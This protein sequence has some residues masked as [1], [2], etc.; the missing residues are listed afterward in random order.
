MTRIIQFC[1]RTETYGKTETQEHRKISLET[2]DRLELSKNRTTTNNTETIARSEIIMKSWEYYDE[3]ISEKERVAQLISLAEDN[4]FE[5][6]KNRNGELITFAEDKLGR[7][8]MIECDRKGRYKTLTTFS[9]YEDRIWKIEK[10][11]HT[12]IVFFDFGKNYTE[13][14]KTAS[15]NILGQSTKEVYCYENGKPLSYSKYRQSLFKEDKLIASH[16]L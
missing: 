1:P 14:I 15:N 2:K 9:P 8:V 3:A 6:M 13:V 7:Y 5:D 16:K 4:D 10:L 11:P 12:K